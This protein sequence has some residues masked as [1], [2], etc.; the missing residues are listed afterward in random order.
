MGQFALVVSADEALRSAMMGVLAAEGWT[1]E[2]VAPAAAADV[3]AECDLVI[4]APHKQ[5]AGFLVHLA[6]QSQLAEMTRLWV[7][8]EAPDLPPEMARIA[9]IEVLTKLPTML[10]RAA[11]GASLEP[12]AA[13]T[14]GIS[15]VEGNAGFI[16]PLRP[17]DDHQSGF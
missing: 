10:A 15:V 7:G 9:R 2:E 5:D 16:K 17:P 12:K 3:V 4:L 13:A 6:D 8:E 14:P 1:A 11:I